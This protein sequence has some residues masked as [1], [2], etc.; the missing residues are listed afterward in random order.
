MQAR[1][2]ILLAALAAGGGLSVQPEPV[3]AQ[4]PSA[5]PTA[6]N[7]ATISD[8]KLDAAAAAAKNVA[9]LSDKY[10][11]QLAQAPEDQKEGVVREANEA[12]TK[13]VT[14]QGLSIEE[15]STIMEVAKNDPEVRDKI[16]KRIK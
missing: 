5:P 13:A 6:P 12:L 10:E 7:P 16:V 4:A 8:A 2:A 11:Q 1:I 9:A 14:D 3:L 15:F